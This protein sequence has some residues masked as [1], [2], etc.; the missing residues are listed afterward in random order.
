MCDWG[1][2]YI[3]VAHC[4]VVVCIGSVIALSHSL[5]LLVLWRVERLDRTA[6]SLAPNWTKQIYRFGDSINCILSHSEMYSG[7]FSEGLG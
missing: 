6:G 1:Y 2:F 4:Q 3:L 7:L 5:S